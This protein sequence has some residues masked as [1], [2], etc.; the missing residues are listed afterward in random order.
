MLYLKTS[1]FHIIF[2][3]QVQG[4][5]AESQKITATRR[6]YQRAIINPMQGIETI[7]RD[8][9][10]YENSINPHIAKKLTEERS[11]DYMNARRV[12]KEYEIITKGLSRNMPSVPPQVTPFEV[13]QV[14]SKYFLHQIPC[15]DR[16]AITQYSH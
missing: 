5:Y 16:L 15:N 3:S 9:C 4:S 2:N 6:V 11:R 14:N 13:K 1:D 7:W 8:Y 10:M 12:T